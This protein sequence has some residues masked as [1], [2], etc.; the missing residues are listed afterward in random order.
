MEE[1]R[2]SSVHRSRH[3]RLSKYDQEVLIRE[4]AGK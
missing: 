4:A 1:D 2:H 3:I